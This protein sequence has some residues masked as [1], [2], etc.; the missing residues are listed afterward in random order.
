MGSFAADHV[1]LDEPAF[2][3]A[4]RTAVA[5]AQ[6][7]ALVTIGLS[8]T[9]PETGYG[10]LERSDVEEARTDEGIAYAAVRF[11]EKPDLETATGYLATGRFLW[12]ASMFIWRVDVFLRELERLLPGLHASL[13]AIA[14][15]W[16]APDRDRVVGELWAALSEV[17]IDHGVME[18][19]SRVAV[20]PAEI[21]W[22]DVGDWHGLGELLPVDRE[23]NCLNGDVVQVGSSDC[24]VWSESG[25]MVALVGQQ[26]TVVVDLPDALLVVDRARAQDVKKIVDELKRRNRI[27]LG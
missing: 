21:G 23:G 24:V 11:V 7:G 19:A 4:V 22:S 8:P 12:N 2:R 9:R 17:T 25:R 18:H 1:V 26:G 3:A 15:V 5:A 16:H 13:Q 27:E 10:Y 14:D 6:D 20:V